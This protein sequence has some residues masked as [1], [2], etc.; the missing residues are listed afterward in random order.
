MVC[1]RHI[2]LIRIF[3][4]GWSGWRFF[5]PS[6]ASTGEKLMHNSYTKNFVCLFLL[7]VLAMPGIAPAAS[8]PLKKLDKPPLGEN[9]F[10]IYV[11]NE[12]V[13]FYRQS[14]AETA[15]GYRMEGDGSVRV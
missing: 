2:W 13:G 11:D 4:S 12:R 5:A 15:D 7:V 6:G 3:N 1:M 14:I 8:S 9:W 10:G